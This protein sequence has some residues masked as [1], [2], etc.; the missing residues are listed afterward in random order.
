MSAQVKKE[1][2]EVKVSYVVRFEEMVETRKATIENCEKVLE[3]QEYLINVLREHDANSEEKH[4]DAL[5][6]QIDNQVLELR[7]YILS[8]KEKNIKTENLITVLKSNKNYDAVA[9]LVLDEVE[10]F[11]NRTPEAPKE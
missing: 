10:V 11:A 1:T 2:K 5:I 6:E 9:T 8:L 4:F 3:Q 7:S